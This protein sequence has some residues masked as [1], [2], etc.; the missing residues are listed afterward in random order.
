MNDEIEIGTTT[1]RYS[2]IRS[3]RKTLG[4][5]LGIEGIVVRA[6]AHLSSKIIREKVRKKGD[7]IL[8]K[9]EKINEIEP[10]PAPKEFMSGE[11]LPY[12]GRRYRLK[13]NK[14]NNGS[15]AVGVKLY[16]GEFYIKVRP[17][18]GESERRTKIRQALINWYR[19]H[20]K[21]KILERVEKYQ[22]K[23]GVT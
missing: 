9:L 13:V 7:W 17:Q 2:I 23:I 21:K 16:H 12:L 3:N 18:I 5:K 4:I 11:K 20:A 14:A 6:P 8:R 1:I 15:G 19:S 10:K 22:S